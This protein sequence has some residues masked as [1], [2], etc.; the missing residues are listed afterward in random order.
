M[1]V[2]LSIPQLRCW[3]ELELTFWAC[4]RWVCYL[5]GLGGGTVHRE[6][7]GLYL[8]GYFN[9]LSYGELWFNVSITVF[10]L[11]FALQW[12]LMTLFVCSLLPL[13]TIA[14]IFNG[15]VCI[16]LFLIETNLQELWCSFALNTWAIWDI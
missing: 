2:G 5:N 13:L 4:V 1:Y 14:P 9:L 12:Y 7:V 16:P 6:R 15:Y 10:V 8:I 11:M 3:T